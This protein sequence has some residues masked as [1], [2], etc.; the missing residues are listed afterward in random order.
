MSQARCAQADPSFT[1]GFGR[2]ET[3]GF[4][5]AA[6][7]TTIL[8]EQDDP[9]AATVAAYVDLAAIATRY[10]RF[11]NIRLKCDPGSCWEELEAIGGTLDAFSSRWLWAREC[12]W[13]HTSDIQVHRWLASLDGPPFP[14]G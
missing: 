4:D 8:L 7:D 1:A 3:Q 14:S 5:E 12:L 6:L 2:P 10:S 9:T 13:F 11:V